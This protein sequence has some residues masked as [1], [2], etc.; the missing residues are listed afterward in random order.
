MTP[1]AFLR[2]RSEQRSFRSAYARLSARDFAILAPASLW[3]AFFGLFGIGSNE[4]ILVSH[5]ERDALD[6]SIEALSAAKGIE[7]TDALILDATV[8]PTRA[9][10]VTR[11]GLY[12]LRFFDVEHRQ[13]EEIVAL[14]KAAWDRFEETD[15]YRAE[16]LALFCQ[17]DRTEE[18]GRML[19]VTWYDGLGSWQTSRRPAPQATELFR[20]RHALTLGTVAYAT[21]LIPG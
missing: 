21:R 8:R 13:V 20:R 4:M 12:V 15:A 14:S 16:P 9:D 1:F 19:L 3:G 7:I 2:I 10:P 11:E 17:H 6:T 18:T 5:G